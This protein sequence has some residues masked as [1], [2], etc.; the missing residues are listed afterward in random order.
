MT[1][2]ANKGFD[3]ELIAAIEGWKQLTHTELAIAAQAM[4]TLATHADAPQWV[5]DSAE[6]I[7][8]DLRQRVTAKQGGRPRS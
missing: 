6:A 4:Y 7:V 8:A 3:P 5:R 1:T 2:K